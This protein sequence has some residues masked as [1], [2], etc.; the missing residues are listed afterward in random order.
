MSRAPPHPIPSQLKV[1]VKTEASTK[2]SP[3]ATQILRLLDEIE[4]DMLTYAGGGTEPGQP[5][6]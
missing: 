6:S 2:A 5:E 3:V 1:V 4:R